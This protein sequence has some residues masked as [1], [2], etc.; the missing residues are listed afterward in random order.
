M[1]RRKEW[2]KYHAEKAYS[3]LNRVAIFTDRS[4]MDPKTHFSFMSIID[5]A[6]RIIRLEAEQSG[7][8]IR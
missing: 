3:K 8:Q 4:Q 7:V 2:V 6:Q 1:A 5:R